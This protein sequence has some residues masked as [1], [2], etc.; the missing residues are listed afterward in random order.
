MKERPVRQTEKLSNTLFSFVPFLGGQIA[1]RQRSSQAEGTDDTPPPTVKMAILTSSSAS[2]S[3]SSTTMIRRRRLN[4]GGVFTTTRLTA[5]ALT[6]LVFA[7]A[8]APVSVDADGDANDE[9]DAELPP[10]E[11]VPLH[12]FEVTVVTVG[13][14]SGKEKKVEKP[15]FFLRGDDASAAAARFIYLHSLPLD[16]LAHFKQ[17]FQNEW[18]GV[19][20]DD[21]KPRQ[22]RGRAGRSKPL[23]PKGFLERGKEH[24]AAGRNDEAH[25]DYARAITGEGVN[26]KEMESSQFLNQQG[27]DEAKE[28]FQAHHRKHSRALIAAG[29]FVFA[30]SIKTSHRSSERLKEERRGAAQLR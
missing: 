2:S 29:R 1:S 12:T 4:G 15:A 23:G 6:M 8:T 26:N 21:V 9:D 25:F 7:L 3:S 13:K 27:L 5:V 14:A 10:S 18:E 16:H 28:L 24:A 22:K 19:V 20:P 17:V 11:D 30:H